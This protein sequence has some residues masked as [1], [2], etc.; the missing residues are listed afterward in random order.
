MG[1]FRQFRA[2]L[3]KNVLLKARRPRSTCF[4]LT[5]PLVLFLLLVYVRGSYEVVEYG[6]AYFR[7]NLISPFLG[8]LGSNSDSGSEAFKGHVARVNVSASDSAAMSD[9][10]TSP[11]TLVSSASSNSDQPQAPCPDAPRGSQVRNIPGCRPEDPLDLRSMIEKDIVCSEQVMNTSVQFFEQILSLPGTNGT[12]RDDFL[13]MSPATAAC[14][15]LQPPADWSNLTCDLQLANTANCEA[16]RAGTLNDGYC[17]KTCGVCQERTTTGSVMAAFEHLQKSLDTAVNMSDELRMNYLASDLPQAILDVAPAVQTVVQ[18]LNSLLE[19]PGG[20]VQARDK[21]MMWVTGN[22]SGPGGAAN[23]TWLAQ[24][25]V[26]ITASLDLASVND[27]LRGNS[28][29]NTGY[30]DTVRSALASITPR[31]VMLAILL[32]LVQLEQA[33]NTVQLAGLADEAFWWVSHFLRSRSITAQLFEETQNDRRITQNL[34]SAA[35]QFRNSVTQ[36]DSDS[37]GAL[38]RTEFGQAVSALNFAV[39]S[40]IVGDVFDQMSNDGTGMIRLDNLAQLAMPGTINGMLSNDAAWF[41]EGQAAH[42]NTKPSDFRTEAGLDLLSGLS[43]FRSEAQ[44]GTI[45]AIFGIEAQSLREALDEFTGVP[46]LKQRSALDVLIDLTGNFSLGSAS[47]ADVERMLPV[48]NWTNCSDPQLVALGRL[49][50]QM[51]ERCPFYRTVLPELAKRNLSDLVVT[52]HSSL[53]ELDLKSQSKVVQAFLNTSAPLIWETVQLAASPAGEHRRRGSATFD[54][55]AQRLSDEFRRTYMREQKLGWCPDEYGRRRSGSRSRSTDNDAADFIERELLRRK[56]LVA[57]YKGDVKDLIDL[58]IVEATFSLAEDSAKG[59]SESIATDILG[60][61]LLCPLVRGLSARAIAELVKDRMLLLGSEKELEDYASKH[62]TDVLLAISFK[63]VDQATGNFL[64]GP[65]NLEYAIRAHAQLLPATDRILRNSRYSQFGGTVISRYPYIEL[66]FT[67]LQEIMGRA[68][69]RL[70]SVH[71]ARSGTRNLTEVGRNIHATARTEPGRRLHVTLEQFPAPPYTVDVFIM[72]IQYMLPMFFVLGWIYSV[73][74][75]VREVVYE[76]QE[77]LRDVM[78]IQGLTTWVYWAS[79]VTSA[80]VQLTALVLLL[81]FILTAGG[82]I[83]HSDPTV[84]FAFFFL[85]SISTVSFSMLISSFFSRAKVAAAC[86]GLAYWM[87]YIPSSLYNRY[88]EALSLEAKNAFCLLSPTGLA[89]GTLL[90]GKWEQ[91]GVGVQWQNLFARSPMTISGNAPKDGHCMAS[92]FF[93]MVVDSIL[94]Q[95]LA[96]YIE[97]VNPGMLGLPQPWYFPLLPSYWRSPKDTM[98]LSFAKDDSRTEKLGNVDLECWEPPSVA[99]AGATSVQIR[100][101]TKTFGSGKQALRGIT[102]DLHQGTIL[103]LLGHNG[104]GKSTTMSILTGLY[105][106]TDGDVF[107]HGVSVRKDSIGVR[108]Q[109]GVCLQHNALYENVTVEEHLRLFCH[110][111]SVPAHQVQAEVEELLRD[112]GLL[113]KRRAPSRALSGGMKRKLSIGIALAGGS[114]VVTLDEPTAG[115]DATSRRDIWQLLVKY[116]AGRTI[117]LSTH[118]MDE[119][120]I[121]SDRIAIIAEGRLTAIASSMTL[122]RRFADGYLLTVVCADSADVT[123]LSNVVSSAVPGSSFAGARGRE[124]SYVLPFASRSHFPALLEQLQDKSKRDALQV[125]AFGLSA[126]SMEEVFLRASSVHE[127]GLHGMIRNEAHVADALSAAVSGSVV[128]AVTGTG[129]VE[130]SDE[131]KDPKDAQG[132]STLGAT[133]I[134]MGM[135]ISDRVADKAASRDSDR[136]ADKAASRESDRAADKVASRDSDNDRPRSP[137]CMSSDDF[138]R[139]A[140]DDAPPRMVPAQAHVDCDKQ[141]KMSSPELITGRRLFFQQFDAL[142]RKRAL[143]VRRDR[144]AWASQLLL[145]AIFIFL[146][147]L[148]ARVLETKENAP[149]LKLSTDMFIG[150]L[151]SNWRT[152]GGAESH[153]IPVADE[154]HGSYCSS[155]LRAFEGGKGKG[156]VLHKIDDGKKGAMTDYFMTQKL[157][158]TY[159]AVSMHGEAG[160]FAKLVL[161]FKNT[162]YHG[163]PVMMNLWNNARLRLLGFDEGKI[164]VWSHPLPKTQALLQEELTGQSQVA[165]DL[166]VALT[167]I[168]AMGFIPASFVVY[169]VHE[170]ATNGKHQQLLTGVTPFMYW[171]SSYCWDMVNFVVPLAVCFI[172]FGSF[173]VMAYSGNNTFAIFLLLLC[174]GMC[175]TPLMYCLDPLFAVA[176]TAYVTLICTNIFTGTI[177]VLAIMTLEVYVDDVPDLLPLLDF[178]FAVFPWV[179]PNYCLGRGMLKIAMNHYQNFIYTE[180]GVCVHQN[181][182]GC[183]KDP[184]SMDVAGDLV[185]SLVIMAPVWFAT[186]MLIEKGFCVRRLRARLMDRIAKQGEECVAAVMDEAVR[187]EASRITSELGLANSDRLVV[188]DLEKSFVSRQGCSLSGIW[189]R[190]VRG[191]NVGVPAGECFG[192]LGVNG[193]GKTTTMRMITGD[194]EIGK[195]D[196]LVG[197]ASVRTRRDQARRHLGYCPQ[198][199]A[200]PDK[201]TVRETIA[202]YARIRGLPR[203]EIYPTVDTMISRMCLEAHQ[204]SLCEHLSGGNKRKLSTAMALIGEPDVVLLDEPST[205]VDV[206]ARRFLW[207][208]IGNL[209][210]SGHAVVLTSH[211]MEECEVLCT[212]L[213]IMAHGQFRCLG[214]PTEL[215][216]K[217]GGGYSLLVK[218]LPDQESLG[219]ELG[220]NLAQ[221]IEFVKKEIPSA[222]L[223]EA[224]VGLA[225]YHLK[226]RAGERED[227]PELLAR[228]FQLFENAGAEGGALEGALSDY[229]VSQTS[230]EEVFL[231]FSR[232]AE[233]LVTQSQ[234][235]SE[236]DAASPSAEPAPVVIPCGDPEP[237]ESAAAAVEEPTIVRAATP[238][239]RASEQ[240]AK[241]METL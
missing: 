14:V 209:R 86:A 211:S 65:Q 149:P 177:S 239:G 191:I 57:P 196:V 179:L 11:S 230:L 38:D 148:V 183:Y 223:A 87:A 166:L 147:L 119:A 151:S 92:V 51:H 109:L 233:G 29:S 42:V 129:E 106:P 224:S 66:G 237:F 213:T 10:A 131:L 105:P 136:V 143:S 100:N 144:K 72:V 214:S 170:K 5:L 227:L 232:E 28:T 1:S 202:L 128:T 114:R 234:A 90:I 176:S 173:Q 55:P 188:R 20:A 134:V 26:Q 193:A 19:K 104:A 27:W 39:P 21:I 56:V 40:D 241:V 46:V 43:R 145:P 157:D 82:L 24:Q 167:V 75:L 22:C 140:A 113:A 4:E 94:Y 194:T 160:G 64:H 12:L 228:I 58:A 238:L 35:G 163:I 200:L 127:K 212:R 103:G 159:S 17:A 195:G 15:D 54:T 139:D 154:C 207:D 45:A 36:W 180:F 108:R 31:N 76:K 18:D 208:L 83:K 110:L 221:I 6:A 62:P 178:G 50:E 130:K 52:A 80:M 60:D 215:K 71:E 122:K 120:D 69:A 25:L 142:I 37:N 181:V 229:A 88:E 171:L 99:A 47:A 79:W 16:R 116:K 8:V 98:Q 123:H 61:L 96:W 78:R 77:R 201:L 89:V 174:Y 63:S 115:V 155:V 84:L 198:F 203:C 219:R 49:V 172:L 184:L 150:T 121:L 91:I 161:W 74:L 240:Q 199:D 59:K 101:L 189:T 217:Y 225:R 137:Q 226:G 112:T 169:L 168:L 97:K 156:D 186:R 125:D 23:R 204:N 7:N 146:A 210:T 117:L 135:P 220:S 236:A 3:R 32:G 48:L 81:V 206:G 192:L 158:G 132:A 205:G 231:H 197:G 102:L 85:Y 126:A 218:S 95:L 175:M 70:A 162:A 34:N 111:K 216:A 124:K 118:F 152:Y 222:S 30:D 53:R 235:T 73:S 93:M 141:Q 9:A 187:S 153:T 41:W 33:N 182:E 44:A 13:K 2:L 68:S 133:P 67:M 165:T 190:A 185:L 164:E 138:V 107:V